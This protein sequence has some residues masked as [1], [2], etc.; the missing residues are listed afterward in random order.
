MN[1]EEI[2]KKAIEQIRTSAKSFQ[3]NGVSHWASKNGN[4]ITIWAP[5]RGGYT[6][7]DRFEVNE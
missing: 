2:R 4:Q 3:I 7:L 1:K 6:I 5:G